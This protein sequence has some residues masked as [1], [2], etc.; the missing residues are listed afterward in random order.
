MVTCS[1]ESNVTLL[2]ANRFPPS[3]GDTSPVKFING[4]FFFEHE[5]YNR[6]KW[7]LLINKED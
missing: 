6:E 2:R 7:G 1:P 4:N 3:T 5:Q